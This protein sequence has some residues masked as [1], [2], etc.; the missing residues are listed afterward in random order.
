MDVEL[1]SNM[2]RMLEN[3]LLKRIIQR[4]TDDVTGGRRELYNLH[5]YPFYAFPKSSYNGNVIE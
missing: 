3:K 2:K 5:F 1:V 4:N